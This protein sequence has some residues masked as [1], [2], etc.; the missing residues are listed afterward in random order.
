M[1]ELLAV[2]RSVRDFEKRPIE[3]GKVELLKEAVLR[4]P[5]SRGINPWE[6]IFVDD[7]PTISALSRCREHSAAFLGRAPLN[8]VVLGDTEKADTVIEDCTIA[9]ITLQY[10]AQALGL[11]SCWCQVRL[12][13]HDEGKTA[14]RYVRDLLGV[15]DNFLVECV[16]GVGYPAEARPGH[17]RE[18]L[19]WDK[20]KVNRH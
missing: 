13:R 20:V 2:R 19:H 14:G 9:A 5:S 3:A 12:R 4:S 1:L 15:P 7:P 18:K 16:V 17:S 10:A 8:V 11:G 6:L